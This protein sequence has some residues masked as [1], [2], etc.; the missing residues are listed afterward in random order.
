M[1]DLNKTRSIVCEKIYSVI[2]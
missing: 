2:S 1:A